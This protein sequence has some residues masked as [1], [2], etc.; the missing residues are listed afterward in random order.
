MGKKTQAEELKIRAVSA[1]IKN[2]VEDGKKFVRLFEKLKITLSEVAD[3][4]REKLSI[5]FD[6]E[7]FADWTSPKGIE[8]L[9]SNDTGLK[10]EVIQYSSGL[11]L[12]IDWSTPKVDET[13]PPVDETKPE[14]PIEIPR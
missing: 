7:D 13:K 8:Y 10:A 4:G 12:D 11:R 5:G 6:D 14:N 1:R 9:T 2:E 3:T